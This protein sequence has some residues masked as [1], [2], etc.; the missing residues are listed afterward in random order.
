MVRMRFPDPEAINKLLDASPRPELPTLRHLVCLS[1]SV[2]ERFVEEVGDDED[3]A[4]KGLRE[5][6]LGVE[7]PL[8]EDDR[9]RCKRRWEWKTE[10]GRC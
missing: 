8:E 5:F 1:Q 2:A 7:A 4:R 3:Q 10:W 6:S 9:R